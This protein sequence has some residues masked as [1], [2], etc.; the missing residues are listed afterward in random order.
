MKRYKKNIWEPFKK[1]HVTREEAMKAYEAHGLA[2]NPKILENVEHYNNNIY[3]VEKR[4]IS[5]DHEEDPG[6]IWLSIKRHDRNPI[7]DWRH[8]Q[9]IKNE[10]VGGNYEGVEMYPAEE[11]KVDT[12]NQYHIWIVDDPTYRL[13]FGFQERLV[14][15]S[16]EVKGKA[17]QRKLDNR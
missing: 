7:R 10:I 12:A 15:D 17:K 9:R 6:L 13:P 16:N 1:A 5:S 14:M 11:R 4:R 3:Q 8:F 2:Y